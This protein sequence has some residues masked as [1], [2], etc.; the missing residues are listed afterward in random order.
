M[1]IQQKKTWTP[2]NSFLL[3]YHARIECGEI[4]VGQELWQEL[5]NLKEDFLN[6]A[7]YY[8]TKDA[9]LR[10]DFMERCVRLTKS[11][12]YNKPM[13][14]MLWQKAFIEAVYSFKMS[15][16]T[17]DRFKKVI[18]LIARK[19]TKSETC[20]ALGLSEL[21]VG[22]EG[23]DIVCSSNDDMQASITY[24]AI[25]TMRRLIDPNDL[26]TK[27]NQR[28]IF[29]KVNGSKIFK[30][31]DRTKN[32]EGRNIDFAIVDETHEMKENVIGKSIEQSQSLKDNPKFINITTEGFVVDGYLD[33]E[34]KKARAV[35]NGEDDSLSGQRLLPWLYTQDSEAEIWQDPKTWVKSNPTL[36]IIK[37]WDYLEEQVDVARK[38]KADRI[39]VLSKD[40]NVKQNNVQTWLNLEDYS[41]SAVYDLEDFRGCVCLGAVDL[42]ET[43]DLTCAK[44]LLMKQGDNTKY[45]HTMYF[46]PQS[47]LEDSDDWNAGARY[48][49]WAKAGLLT[50]T[51]GNDIDL[52]LVA[53]WFYKLYK[54][55]NIKLW[56]C[57]YDQRFSKDWISRM[58]FYSWTKENEDL[59]LILQ[60]AQTLSNALKL[61]EADLQHQLVNYN[62]NAMDRWCFKNAGLKIDDH[63]QCLCV[64]TE[65]SKRIDGAVTLIILYEMYRRYRTEYKQIIGG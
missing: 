42:S 64:K 31:S 55:Y 53:D 62:E 10:I 61:C 46:I 29:N 16:T 52:S 23:A 27:R 56:K 26:D 9:L 37:K 59:V 12:Y 48:R 39:F 14:L 38:S 60:N 20:S 3:E 50:I 13:V 47:K 45:I 49:D 1:I 58:G 21:I 25:D 32:K 7:F 8:D 41:Y 43:T 34:L 15:A 5:Q 2:D 11:P 40:F 54:D 6:D 4:L 28:F 24:D 35:I 63:S 22:N 17:F 36:G 44:I 18:L 30:L 65:R 57:G 33:D 51:E 19:N